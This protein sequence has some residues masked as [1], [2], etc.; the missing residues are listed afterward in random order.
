MKILSFVCTE[1]GHN[2]LEE[3]LKVLATKTSPITRI[4]TDGEIEYNQDEVSYDESG[5][6]VECYQCAECGNEII[7]DTG[8]AITDNNALAAWLLEQPYNE[9][10]PESSW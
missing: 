4:S 10:V 2:R 8:E 3:V 5:G 1:C 7:D 6:D 9:S